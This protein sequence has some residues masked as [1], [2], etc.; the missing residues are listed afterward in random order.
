M[1]VETVNSIDNLKELCRQY[2]ESKQLF[3]ELEQKIKELHTEIADIAFKKNLKGN[4]AGVKIVQRKSFLK[5]ENIEIARQNGIEIPTNPVEDLETLI[6]IAK[7]QGIPIPM[8]NVEDM[9][10]LKKLLQENKIQIAYTK[11]VALSIV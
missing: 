11:T 7:E 8:K 4:F 5:N 10:A 9:K 2:I 1:A 6:E 3:D